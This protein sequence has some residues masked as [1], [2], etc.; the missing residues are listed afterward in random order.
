MQKGGRALARRLKFRLQDGWKPGAKWE[1]LNYLLITCEAC[2]PPISC[3]V[4]RDRLGPRLFDSQFLGG[5]QHTAYKR[6][7]N[8]VCWQ[9]L[10]N[11]FGVVLFPSPKK[12]FW[13]IN[14]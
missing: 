6:V 7:E 13:P 9:S 1:S 14:C 10:I 11:R 12:R 5:T 4:F 3:Q 8:I 2:H